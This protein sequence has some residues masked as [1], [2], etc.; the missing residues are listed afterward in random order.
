M[1]VAIRQLINIASTTASRLFVVLSWIRNHA[2]EKDKNEK[3][4][5]NQ[6]GKGGIMITQRQQRESVEKKKESYSE[7]YT[8]RKGTKIRF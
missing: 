3:R 1:A 8:R 4:K 7:K 5:S 2:K 6:G